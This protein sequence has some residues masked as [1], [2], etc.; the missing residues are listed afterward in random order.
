QN[1]SG[2]NGDVP[3][4]AWPDSVPSLVARALATPQGTQSRQYGY[5]DTNIKRNYVYQYNLNI[6]RQLTPS[7]TLTVAYAG[8]RGLHN[9]IQLDAAN[10]VIGRKTPVGYV[11]PVPWTYCSAP[12]AASGC[13]AA[14]AGLSAAPNPNVGPIQSVIWASSSYYNSV[15]LRL[16][17]RMSRGLQVQGS[18]TWGKS[19]DNSSAS[20]AGD[21]FQNSLATIPRYDMS[22]SKGLSDFDIRRALVIT[23]LWNALSPKSLGAFGT[24]LL[25]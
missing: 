15:Q 21:T 2:Q 20:F 16:D 6:Q 23:A 22:L 14:G 18:F 5:R 19:L 9:P 11:W 13:A 12:D 7:T 10:G 25:G 1:V 24:W 8:S 17:K 4:G 3:S